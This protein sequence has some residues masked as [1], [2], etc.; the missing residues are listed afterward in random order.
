M[1]D[2]LTDCREL[3]GSRPTRPATS[4]HQHFPGLSKPPTT[5]WGAASLLVRSTPLVV[6]KLIGLTGRK[7]G[8]LTVIR[9]LVNDKRGQT[10]WLCLCDCGLEKELRGSKITRG[11]TRS[12]GCL[13]RDTHTEHGQALAGKPTP[14]YMIWGSII[15]RTTSLKEGDPG[16]ENYKGR[17]IGVCE[18]WRDFR[19]FVADMG[20]RPSPK[21]TIERVDNNEGYSAENCRWASWVEQSRNRRS[22]RLPTHKGETKCMAEWS[23]ITGI[24]YGAIKSR[25]QR[26]WDVARSL[27]TP[28]QTR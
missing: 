25:L 26:G 1:T 27:E 28:V 11:E 4:R 24:E 15:R 5:L 20:P 23:E 3:V 21:H 17:G 16:Y 2:C 13:I 12:C 14:E 8:R 22:N 6:M 9:R 19:N 18:R 7:F 10:R